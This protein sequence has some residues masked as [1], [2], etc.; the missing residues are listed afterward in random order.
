MACQRH[1]LKKLI[2][3]EGQISGL[4][5]QKYTDAKTRRTRLIQELQTAKRQNWWYRRVLS[6]TQ[7][8]IDSAK[9]A[10]SQLRQASEFSK[11]LERIRSMIFS[12]DG[13]VGI[14]LRSWALGVI[15]HKASE[16]ASLLTLAFRESNLQK[17]HK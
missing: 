11:M 10:I 4:S 5:L 12:R 3:C 2:H 13:V 1:L 16:Y 7:T 17:R 9:H 6:D 15:S 8:S 14:S